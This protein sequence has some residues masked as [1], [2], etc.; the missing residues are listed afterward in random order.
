MFKGLNAKLAV[1]VG[2]KAS[3]MFQHIYYWM[4]TQEVDI[5]YRTNKQLVGDLENMFSE[6]QIQRAKKKLVDG[7]FITVSFDKKNVWSRTTHYSLTEKGK[8]YVLDINLQKDS[9]DNRVSNSSKTNY[10]YNDSPKVKQEQN[11][12]V[13][14]G[15]RNTE[16]KESSVSTPLASSKAM[17]DSFKEGFGNKDAVK[18]PSDFLKL[19][20]KKNKE[21]C[22]P[23]FEENEDMSQEDL[24]IL[25]MQ[26]KQEII[27]QSIMDEMMMTFEDRHDDNPSLSFSDLLKLSF[28]KM[29]T[30]D[31]EV[32]YDMNTKKQNFIEDY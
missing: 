24:E 10:S 8:K 7:G 6:Q 16:N 26:E 1:I 5:V 9:D 20:G 31:Q 29:V 13:Y 32:L 14:K 4:K 27:D 2:E 12:P 19:L 23:Y 15:S 17:S 3:I 21:L 25:K 11:K 28:N 22:N 30:N 18:P